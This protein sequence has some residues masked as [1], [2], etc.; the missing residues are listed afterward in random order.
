MTP[1]EAAILE[2]LRANPDT[3]RAQIRAGVAPDS[4]ESTMW[5]A[6]KGLVENGTLSVTGRGPATR[7][8]LAGVARINAHLEAPYYGRATV[9]YRREFLDAYVPGKTAYLG[10][11]DRAQLAAAGAYPE[12]LP[13]GTYARRILTRLLVDLAWASSRMEG[14]TYEIL[15]TERLIE[16]GQEASGR[17]RAEAL[18]ILN[19]RDAIEYVVDHLADAD[20]DRRTLCDLHALLANGLLYDPALG[21]RLR[22]LP[23][24]IGR[25]AYLPLDD[26]FDVAAAFETFLNKAKAI[27]NP[28]EQSFFVLAHLPYLQP[29]ADVNKRTSRVAANVPLLKAGL[30]PLSFVATDDRQYVD[31]LLG[32]YELNEIALLKQV[33]LTSYVA[34]ARQYTALRA[35]MDSPPKAA[36]THRD[37]VRQAVRR[38]VFDWGAF[39]RQGVLSMAVLAG[40]PEGEL[41]A[42]AKYVEGEVN[43]LHEGNAIRYSL[44]PE[45]V[46]RL[47]RG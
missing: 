28:F 22:R 12:S 4:S 44:P 24:S 9:G 36:L 21:G 31:G 45:S 14:N 43:G 27:A 40:I 18:M 39:R 37:F 42:V 32:V 29:F 13:A 6:L 46:S 38:C 35:Q 26:E 3:S 7:Y 17:D 11:V 20:I 10:D 1:S 47:H 33:Y 19:H 8:R 25:S 2:F 16:A 23:V 5:R 15:E 30:A 34:T 41:D